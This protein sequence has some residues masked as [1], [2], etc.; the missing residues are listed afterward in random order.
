MGKNASESTKRFQTEN[1]PSKNSDLN[2]W[3]KTQRGSFPKTD[4]QNSCADC[5]LLI[6]HAICLVQKNFLHQKN[7]A[8]KFEK[9]ID[10]QAQKQQQ[11]GTKKDR[12]EYT[13]LPNRVQKPLML[14]YKKLL[15]RPCKICKIT[16]L[17]SIVETPSS[18]ALPSPRTAVAEGGRR[19]GSAETKGR[20]GAGAE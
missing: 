14:I 7:P 8:Q 3:P 16:L 19:K 17:L 2:F 12:E 18:S 1:H 10:T 9:K 20:G 6:A 13:V 11:Q 15:L 5:V 4:I